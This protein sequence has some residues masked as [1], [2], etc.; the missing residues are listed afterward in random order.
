[1]PAAVMP[2]TTHKFHVEAKG[3]SPIEWGSNTVVAFGVGRVDMVFFVE[4]VNSEK[5]GRLCLRLYL[6]LSFPSKHI[7]IKKIVYLFSSSHAIS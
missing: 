4:I 1:M 7:L 2:R 3:V 5:N 6:L